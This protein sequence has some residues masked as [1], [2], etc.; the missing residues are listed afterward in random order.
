MPSLPKSATIGN[1]NNTLNCLVESCTMPGVNL[2]KPGY[3]KAHQ[4]RI[5]VH[6]NPQENIPLRTKSLTGVC[7]VDECTRKVQARGMCATH[8]WRLQTWGTLSEEGRRLVFRREIGYR[9]IDSDGYV[10]IKLPEHLE[11]HANG[12]V[13]E[14]RMVI[15]DSLGRRLLPSENVHHINGKRDDNRPENLEL[16]SSAQPSG[17]RA[18]DKITFAIEI[19]RL[20]RP[21]LLK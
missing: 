18:E 11:A 20:Y 16:W 4:R 7:K 5:R 8:D 17:Q 21:E 3:C 10:K 1:M 19:L 9:R 6:G 15:S 13:Y 2:H 14:H 12:W